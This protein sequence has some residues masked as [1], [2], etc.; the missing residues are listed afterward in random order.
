M[1]S[2]KSYRGA[3]T[4]ITKLIHD[5]DDVYYLQLIRAFPFFFRCDVTVVIICCLDKMGN[6]PMSISTFDHG[7]NPCVKRGEHAKLLVDCA[8]CDELSAA[9]MRLPVSFR[10]LNRKG[11]WMV[12]GHSQVQMGRWN[13]LGQPSPQTTWAAWGSYL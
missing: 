9:A 5:D 6:T 3:D 13:M 8:V 10:E 2:A 4:R 7:R 12:A 1:S 11:I